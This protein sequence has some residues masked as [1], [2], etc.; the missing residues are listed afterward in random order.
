[1]IL[2]EKKEAGVSRQNGSILAGADQ[3]RRRRERLTVKPAAICLYLKGRGLPGSARNIL[4]SYAGEARI[5]REDRKHLPESPG[6]AVQ[7][8][9]FGSSAALPVS[10]E[11]P[12]ETQRRAAVIIPPSVRLGSCSWA[13]P[14]WKGIVWSRYSST[15]DLANRG[16]R[17]YS[18][19]PLLRT[20]GIDRAYYRP[21]SVGQYWRFADQVPEGFRFVVK[22][23]AQVTD[24]FIRGRNGRP[25]RA[26]PDFLNA[27]LASDVF[28]QPVSEGLGAKAG[29]LV[30]EMAPLPH[31]AVNTAEKRIAMV[32]RIG[33]FFAALP[34][35]AE[36]APHAF[37]ACEL[38][39]PSL[40][41][42]R[43]L[44]VLKAAGAR[45]AVGLHPSMPGAE[46]QAAALMHSDDPQ[47]DA[48]A[49]RLSGPL[50]I[51]WTLALGDR[52]DDA[53]RRFEPFSAIQRPDPVTRE[54]IASLLMAALRGGQDAYVAVNNKAEG[55]A[56]LSVFSIAERLT[57]KIARAREEA[58][59][60]RMLPQRNS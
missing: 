48:A 8:D 45:H 47:A 44:S 17:A 18:A 58:E 36:N 29:P 5:M 9:F 25:L 12:S 55:S 52:F 42:P 24:Y 46:R 60:Q 15:D 19:N 22:A 13:F 31:E 21:L 54:G 16:L 56:P 33:A 11:P 53:R 6:T 23:P 3:K 43:Y 39:T 10:P 1:M 28:L 59:R 32:E 41:T 38:R 51:R 7:E 50:V 14:G 49:F 30:F 27:K 20:A 37:A 34:S 2:K 26:N 40:F 4:F 35:V 57:E